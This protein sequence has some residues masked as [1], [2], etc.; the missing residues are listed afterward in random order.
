VRKARSGIHKASLDG[1]NG[2]LVGSGMLLA[3]APPRIG[4]V[5]YPRVTAAVS[6]RLSKR[7]LCD[8]PSEFI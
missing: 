6:L 2:G 5:V 3:L 8:V 4:V 1:G 7:Y